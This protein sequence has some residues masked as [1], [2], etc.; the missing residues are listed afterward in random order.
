M[1]D[2]WRDKQQIVRTINNLWQ[3]SE[4]LMDRL[5]EVRQQM[6]DF[7][8]QILTALISEAEKIHGQGTKIKTEFIVENG[9]ITGLKMWVNNTCKILKMPEVSDEK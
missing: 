8:N 7:T 6:S 5:A 9:L 3:D 1:L 2:A 4:N